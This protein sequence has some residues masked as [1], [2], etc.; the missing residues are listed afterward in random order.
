[1]STRPQRPSVGQFIGGDYPHVAIVISVIL[2]LR[3]RS[4]DIG[5]EQPVVIKRSDPLLIIIVEGRGVFF[6]APGYIDRSKIEIVLGVRLP[7]SAVVIG[8]GLE[9]LIFFRETGP[10]PRAHFQLVAK[11]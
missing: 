8:D 6:D 3:I 10:P 2:A 11:L 1:M 5:R 7:I 9:L 4:V